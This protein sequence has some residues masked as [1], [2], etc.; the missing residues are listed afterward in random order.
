MPVPLAD[1]TTYPGKYAND[2]FVFK[3]HIISWNCCGVYSGAFLIVRSFLSLAGSGN[4]CRPSGCPS[5]EIYSALLPDSSCFFIAAH[6]AFRA[7]IGSLVAYALY[8]LISSLVVFAAAMSSAHLFDRL[9]TGISSGAGSAFSAGF[10]AGFGAD[11]GCFLTIA[12]S[13]SSSSSV[14]TPNMLASAYLREYV[15]ADPSACGSFCF[16]HTIGHSL[17]INCPLVCM[18]VV[19]TLSLIHI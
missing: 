2:P 5:G 9:P 19:A 3:A 11:C 12:D 10:A 17:V 14:I 8:M 6:A 4:T 18:I 1:R 15:I 16:A 13:A 7:A